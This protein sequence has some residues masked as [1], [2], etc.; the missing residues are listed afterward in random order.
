M[1]AT[2]LNFLSELKQTLQIENHLKID[3]FEDRRAEDKFSN[4]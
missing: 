2:N 1:V 4:Y 3:T